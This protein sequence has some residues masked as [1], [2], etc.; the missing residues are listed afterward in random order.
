MRPSLIYS[1]DRPASYVPVGAFF[2]GNSV[3]LPFVD[4]PVTVQAL[5]CA[6]VRA[7]DRDI[8]RYDLVNLLAA[9]LRPAIVVFFE[10]N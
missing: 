2:L 5:S 8:R 3:G 9:R 6:I 1:L 10:S 7:M 4:L